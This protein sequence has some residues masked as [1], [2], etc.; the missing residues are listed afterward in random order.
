MALPKE[1]NAPTVKV[2][3]TSWRPI[4]DQFC[5]KVKLNCSEGKSKLRTEPDIEPH[6][7]PERI[8]AEL[9]KRM[10]LSQINSVYDPLGL[11]GPFTVRTK[12][13]MRQLWASETKLDWGESVPEAC[14]EG[15]FHIYLT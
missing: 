6:Q 4:E 14:R 8:P 12:I 9:T 15:S 3:G 13:M 7:I 2:L 1:T 11:A 5:F 10:I